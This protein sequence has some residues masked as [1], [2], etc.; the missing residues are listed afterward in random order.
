V[1]SLGLIRNNYE[2][3]RFTKMQARA[4]ENGVAGL[5]MVGREELRYMEPNIT[6]EAI[7][8]LYDPDIAITSPFE[9]T[10]ALAENARENGVRIMLATE[11]QDISR[12]AGHFEVTTNKGPLKARYI[13]NAAGIEVDKVASMV[14]AN[15]FVHFPMKGEVCVLDRKVGELSKHMIFA[16]MPEAGMN[17]ITPT[18]YGNIM[19]GIP[20]TLA[21]KNNF[22]TTRKGIEAAIAHAKSLVPSINKKD[23]IRSFAGFMPYKNPETGWHECT[24]E[25]S[26]RVPRFANVSIGFP[27]V[28]AAPATAKKVVEMLADEGLELIEKPD[29][30]PHR[31]RITD[32]SELPGE[33][34]AT[35][36]AKNPKY[37]HVVCRCETVTEGEIIEAIHC[38]ATTVDGIKFRTRAGM[39]RCQ[40]GFCT[41]RVIDILAREL[42]IPVQKVGKKGSGSEQLLFRTKEL[43]K[44]EIG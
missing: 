17:M 13:V 2:L 44:G 43:L 5:R 1:G 16:E 24:V 38:G 14:K 12:Q 31:H 11:V 42:N 39:G 33:G 18:V 15:D 22:G 41:P 7:G 9:L 30:N 36:V 34:K 19:F 27:G 20:L 10:I 32:F 23:I 26:S 37:G 3:G 21:N 40:G 25:P 35:L 8:A 28:S 4:E 29:F 6:E